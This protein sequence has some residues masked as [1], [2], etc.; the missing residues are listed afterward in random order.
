MSDDVRIGDREREQAMAALGEHFAAGRLA[1]AEYEERVAAAA[2]AQ[3]LPELR[4]IFADLPAPHPP[5]M[6]GPIPPMPPPPSG[7]YPGSGGFPTAAYAPPPPQYG[8]PGYGPMAYQGYSDKSKV[9]AG[10]LNILLPFG[11]GRF[12][13][14]HVGIGLAQL[15]LFFAC[16]IGVLWSWIDGIILLINGGTDG[17]GRRLRDS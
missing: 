15:L 14:G 6:I 7:A 10:L 16:G 12:Y 17:Q 8:V 9:A 11:I 1:M 3:Y 2:G 4:S 5:F 13:A